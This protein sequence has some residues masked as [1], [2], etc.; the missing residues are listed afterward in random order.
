MRAPAL[1]RCHWRARPRPAT[2]EKA[3]V[4]QTGPRPTF[5]GTGFAPER[6]LRATMKRNWT[7]AA[8]DDDY[9]PSSAMCGGD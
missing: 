1:G 2:T 4:V 5:R 3:T 6:G 7:A 8:G 9:V